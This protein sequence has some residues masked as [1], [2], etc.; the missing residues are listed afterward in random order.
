MSSG[1]LGSVEASA[2]G[3]GDEVKLGGTHGFVRESV[4][5]PDGTYRID[6]VSGQSVTTPPGALWHRISSPSAHLNDADI[7]ALVGWLLPSAG[8]RLS[9]GGE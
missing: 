4:R 3:V 8:A 5:L 6:F 1:G 9:I 7:A 2:I